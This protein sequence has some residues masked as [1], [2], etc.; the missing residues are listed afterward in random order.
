MLVTGVRLCLLQSGCSRASHLSTTRPLTNSI[1]TF[2]ISLPKTSRE[3]V[4]LTRSLKLA[5]FK[6]CH[7]QLSICQA[8]SDAANSGQAAATDRTPTSKEESATTKSTS[9]KYTSA[10]QARQFIDTLNAEERTVLRQELENVDKLERELQA[11]KKTPTRPTYTQI[12][13]CKLRLFVF[14]VMNHSNSCSLKTV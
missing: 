10:F 9:V 2:A 8:S 11:D 13:L 7:T 3:D 12:M 4:T 1:Y 5:C 6:P 14:N